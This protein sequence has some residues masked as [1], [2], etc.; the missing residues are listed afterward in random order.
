MNK[1]TCLRDRS[2]WSRFLRF[3][4]EEYLITTRSLSMQLSNRLFLVFS[5]YFDWTPRISPV[6]ACAN[7]VRRWFKPAFFFRT[8][9]SSAK[10]LDPLNKFFF[11]DNVP[12]SPTARVLASHAMDLADRSPSKKKSQQ[13]RVQLRPTTKSLQRNWLLRKAQKVELP[14]S[15]GLPYGSM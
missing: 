4:V 11:L 2:Y 7:I 6:V 13:V 10:R 8:R 5:T 15:K 12:C 1:K 3:I 14:S 9:C